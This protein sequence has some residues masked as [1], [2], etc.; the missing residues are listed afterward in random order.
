MKT[1][2]A[3]GLS[4]VVACSADR[5]IDSVS[6]TSDELVGGC[7]CQSSGTCADLSYSDVPS[8]GQ[9]YVTTFGGGTDTGPMACGGTADGTWAYV[10]DKARFGCGAKLLIKGGGKQCVA[11]VADCGPNK[12]VEEAAS[13]SCSTHFPVLDVSPFITKYLLNLSGVG[14]SDHE[15]VTA[16]VVD[17]GSTVGCPGTVTGTGGSGGSGGGSG[18]TPSGGTGGGTAGSGGAPAAC[19]APTCVGC[20]DCFTQC[21]CQTG[22]SQACGASCY[23]PS[24]GGT[25]GN[26]P[27]PT[28]CSAPLCNGCADCFSQCVCDGT[29]EDTCDKICNSGTA[30]AAG[31]PAG[32][33]EFPEC[34]CGSCLDTCLC[35]GIEEGSCSSLCGKADGPGPTANDSSSESSKQQGSCAASIVGS[36]SDERRDAGAFAFL[37]ALG[38][39]RVL[40]R[41]RQ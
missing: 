36:R 28:E 16:Q 38:L 2:L 10:A 7:T 3:L 30:G 5:P 34:A 17:G 11:Q 6:A 37:I 18:G 26:P 20:A 13:G 27:T 21:M 33:C 35:Q 32:V 8:N 12:C 9:Y 19:S 25:G 24:G 40:R 23:G 31:A 22:D 4:L 14:W 29:G 41:R 1:L 15:L 39:V